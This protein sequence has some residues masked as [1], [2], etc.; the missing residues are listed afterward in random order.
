MGIEALI[1]LVIGI[2]GAAGGYA[3]GRRNSQSQALGTAMSTVELLQVQ[4][5]T[6]TA[7]GHAKD[8]VVTDLRARVELLESL[9]TQRARVEEVYT[10]AEGIRTV[11]DRI[12]ERLD[13]A[14]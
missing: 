14:A 8:A 5:N 13:G 4:V 11:V 6:L 1:T 12:E 2:A 7:D 10:L 3:G 9:V